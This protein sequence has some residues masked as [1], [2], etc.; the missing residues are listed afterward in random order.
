MIHELTVQQFAKALKNLSTILEKAD[1]FAQL[2]KIDPSVLCQTRLA[3]D[4]FPLTR[5]VQIACDSAKFSVAK[6]TQKEAPVFE[7]QE[8]TIADLR[9]RIHNTIE[10]LLSVSAKDFQNFEN[11]TI[12]Y[13]WWN[14]KSLTGADFVVQYAIPNFYFH[15]TTAY[16]ILRHCGLEIGKS[17]YL[18]ELPFK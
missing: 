12:T 4:Q 6:L 7:D 10:F 5:Q 1:H 8:K 17:D 15:L 14:G 18:G 2:K 16:S 11:Q 3:V 13:K 9:A